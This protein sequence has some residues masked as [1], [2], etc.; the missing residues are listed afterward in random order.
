MTTDGARR[1]EI[2]ETAAALFASSG[3][4]T[5]LKEIAAAAGILPGSL[6]HHFESKEAIIVELVRRYQDD[7]A[8]VAKEASTRSTTSTGSPSRTGSSTSAKPS[9]RA[10]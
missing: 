9:P 5:P 3:V 7:L 6:Y 4:R 1:E 8:R 2:L 10:R